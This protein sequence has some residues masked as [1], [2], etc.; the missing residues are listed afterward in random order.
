M[1]LIINHNLMA[2][3]AQRTLGANYKKLSTSIQRLSSGLRINSAADDAAG[4]AIREM[5][6][7]DIAVMQQGIRNAS[8]AISLIQTAEG[9]MAVI[10]EKLTRMKELAEQAATGSYT[11]AQRELINSEYQAM[12]AEIDRIANATNF[13][14]I[15]LLD[16]TLA[17]QHGGQGLKVHFGVGNSASED[18]YFISTGDVR[19]TAATGLR[20]GGDAGNDIWAQGGAA[21]AYGG[22][23]GCCAGG[24]DSLTGTAGFQSGQT[25]SYGYNWDWNKN[26]DETDLLSGRY[27]AGRYEVAASDSL[28]DLIDKVNAGVQSRVGINIDA[29]GA[30]FITNGGNMAVCLDDE[31]Y[32]WGDAT[33]AAGY[34]RDVAQFL[35]QYDTG[36][37]Q[38]GDIAANGALAALLKNATGLTLTGISEG[39]PNAAAAAESINEAVN[40]LKGRILAG[41]N[42][43]ATA[44]CASAFVKTVT[45]GEPAQ[46]SDATIKSWFTISASAEG[47]AGGWFI[48]QVS[49]WGG[50]NAMGITDGDTGPL[51]TGI[52]SNGNGIW[53]TS[54]ARGTRLG[55]TEVMV[56]VTND[57]NLSDIMTAVNAALTSNRLSTSG[58]SMSATGEIVVLTTNQLVNIWVSA[59]AHLWTDNAGIAAR[60]GM[61]QVSAGATAG[62]TIVATDDFV[63]LKGK[64]QTYFGAYTT[65]VTSFGGNPTGMVGVT[66]AGAAGIQRQIY[67]DGGPHWTTDADLAKTLGLKALQVQVFSNDTVETI[68]DRLAGLLAGLTTEVTVRSLNRGDIN[69]GNPITAAQ[70]GTPT[71]G[72]DKHVEVGGFIDKTKATNQVGTNID[73][74]MTFNARGLA[75]AINGNGNSKFWAMLDQANESQLYV[76]LKEGGDNNS[77]RACDVYGIDPISQD[78]REKFVSFENVETGESQR[79][80]TYFSLGT[81][82]SNAWGRLSPVQTKADGGIQVW[83]VTLNGRDVG[84]KRDLWIAAAG[85][86]TLP[87][88][89]ESI[90]NGLDRF[91]F[92][93]VQ[94]ASDAPWAGAEIRTQD[95]AQKALAAVGLAIESKD[96]V[97]ATL[98]AYQNRLENTISNLEIQAENLQA[99]E[100]RISDADVAREITE[101]TKNSILVQ[102]ATGMLAQANSLNNLALTLIGRM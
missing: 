48:S 69:G 7:A 78:N 41:A 64:V 40:L 89:D 98:G 58:V 76:F 45:I 16:G 8:D 46:V 36:L 28:Q 1:S 73:A 39:A 49:G 99:S 10:D 61:T 65:K 82:A 29:T 26:T 32:F 50:L 93:E 75:S 100:S 4:L 67:T 3:N 37:L 56:N 15:K 18:Y 6:R 68:G 84:D 94:N 85:E 47:A 74:Y 90:I 23:T 80:G 59:A 17:R 44:V 22:T 42:I 31:A 77:L 35:H 14:G 19:A 72:A 66:S 27:L 102:A 30:G 24:F 88:I 81:T 21:Q 51:T 60:M 25:F 34:S 83:N 71:R 101:F 33:A 55:F 97:R 9:A 12:A 5:M 20:I 57:M 43:N 52:W 95:S 53:T 79:G 92:A 87:N 11:T 96:K 70:L 2:E 13:N 54:A 91:S 86:L 62:I 38:A 63:T